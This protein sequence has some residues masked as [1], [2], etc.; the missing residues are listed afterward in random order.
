MFGG[1]SSTLILSR[2]GF[3]IASSSITSYPAGKVKMASS[4]PG[5]QRTRTWHRNECEELMHSKGVDHPET[6]SQKKPWQNYCER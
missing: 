4:F 3:H 6:G 5:T 1:K 2:G